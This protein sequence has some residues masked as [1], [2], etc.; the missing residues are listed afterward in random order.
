MFNTNMKK[1]LKIVI[2]AI[3][4][5]LV[6][7]ALA[8]HFFLDGAVKKSVERIGPQIT[9]TPVKLD[10]VNIILLSGSGSIKGLVVSNPEGFS[11]PSAIALG[12][13]SLSLKPTSILSKKVIVRS[14]ALER[15][16]ITFEQKLDGNN[17]LTLRKNTMEGSAEEKAEE[18]SGTTKKLQVDDFLIKNGK[19]HV[20]AKL[21]GLGDRSATVPLPEIHLT[22]LGTNESGITPAELTKIILDTLLNESIKEAEKAIADLAKGAVILGKDLGTNANGRVG[23]TLESVGGLLKKKK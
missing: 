20:H 5:L 11:S 2:I 15:P 9:K 6:V 7:A 8:V 14:I 23:K 21:P 3:I 1:L 10:S 22:N 13:A 17:L 19:V 4:L 12:K 16:E 18:E